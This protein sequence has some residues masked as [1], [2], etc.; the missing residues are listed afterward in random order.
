V[1]I[2]PQRTRSFALRELEKVQR[3]VTEG[4]I[5]EKRRR[6]LIAYLH[7]EEKMSQVDIAARLSTVAVTFGGQPIGDDAI[8]KI[9]KAAR[10]TR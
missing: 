10:S 1:Q 6:E 2:A 8:F 9:I 4:Q 3:K 5:A 7:N